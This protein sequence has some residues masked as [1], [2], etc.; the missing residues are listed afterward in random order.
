MTDDII[1][2]AAGYY[3]LHVDIDEDG[4][5]TT[6]DRALIVGWRMLP[7]GAAEPVPAGRPFSWDPNGMYNI[8]M[9]DGRVYSTNAERV[10]W[11]SAEQWE[12][13]RIESL[14]YWRKQAA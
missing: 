8:E 12:R 11:Q 7:C 6:L 14:R 13:E 9:P 1:P 4:D 5:A 10:A 2:A 3:A